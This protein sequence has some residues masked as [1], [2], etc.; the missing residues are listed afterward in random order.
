[1]GYSLELRPALVVLGLA[2]FA[3]PALPAGLTITPTF[4]S[5]ITNDPNAAAIQASINAA[6]AQIESYFLDPINVP[7]T[8][9]TQTSGLG[10]SSTP[11]FQMSYTDYRTALAGD[12]TS[13]DDA[14][15]LAQD[16][17]AQALSPVDGLDSMWV[18]AANLGSLGQDPG[19][20]SDGT[21]F[22]NVSLMSFDH[23]TPAAGKYDAQ[24]VVM[25]EID[26]ILGLGSGLN[27]PTGFPRLSRPQDL[28]RYSAA[29]TRSYTTSSSATSYFSIDGGATN[30]VGFDQTAGGDYG[31]WVSS[32]TARVQD[33]FGT[34]G[35]IPIYG[36][37][38]R[39]LDVIGY[40]IVTTPEP[41]TLLL[42][43]AGLGLLVARRRSA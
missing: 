8:F 12:A 29:G 35:V 16:V 39:G 41:G 37:E 25:H 33:A 13:T 6:I 34:P 24:S 7:I 14:T 28:F 3:L 38:A 20:A 36:V 5:S 43:A 10:G 21:I 42:M 15:A 40:D 30:L 9:Q 31:D 32:S 23:N 22:L 1:M 19:L 27:L 4:D 17:P 18:T 26:E 2:F 11:I